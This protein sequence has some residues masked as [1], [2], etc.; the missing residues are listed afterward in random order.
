MQKQ[1]QEPRN[2]ATPGS[3][4][5]QETWR[6]V[7]GSWDLCL[8]LDREA[9]GGT[10][11]ASFTIALA[12]SQDEI[13][14]ADGPLSPPHAGAGGGTRHAAGAAPWLARLPLSVL[15]P[16]RSPRFHRFWGDIGPG[17]AAVA[18]EAS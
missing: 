1:P 14:G 8:V 18:V 15:G 5:R 9:S 4:I 2:R 17:P 16:T 3:R 12:T 13:A 6:L 7:L 11:I 10:L